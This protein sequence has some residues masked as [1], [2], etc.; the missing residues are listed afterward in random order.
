LFTLIDILIGGNFVRHLR[1]L[2]RE[3]P[4]FVP[5]QQKKNETQNDPDFGK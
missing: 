5:H 4:N 2:M 3:L 1:I